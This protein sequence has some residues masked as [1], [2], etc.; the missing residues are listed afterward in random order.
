MIKNF[1]IENF[2]SI[3]T[4]DIEFGRVNVIIGENGSGKSN[5]LEAIAL[6]TAAAMNKLDREFLASRGI[7]DVEPS[8]MRA[9]FSKDNVDKPITLTANIQS[10]NN[11][12]R[13]KQTLHN[14]NKP[15]SKWTKEREI[16]YKRKSGDEVSIPEIPVLDNINN[17]FNEIKS[18]M[19]SIEKK[20]KE[21]RDFDF[22]KRIAEE[23]SRLNSRIESLEKKR[24]TI[25]SKI[26]SE[27][28]IPVDD[29][30]IYSPE[31]TALRNFYKEGQIEPL[32]VNGE[33]LLKLLKVT[34]ENDFDSFES[35]INYLNVFCWYKGLNISSDNS[36][37][38]LSIQLTDKFLNDV[39][40][41]QR[42]AN[43]G[44]L[45][46]LFYISLIISKETPKYIAI[47]NIDASLN[48]KLCT[49]LMRDIAE[50]AKN[51]DKQLFLTTHNPA[52]LDGL[53]LSDNEQKLFVASRTRE[54]HTKL[55]PL[56]ADIK[57]IQKDGTPMK[58]S[59]A[60][61]RGYLGG[62]PKGF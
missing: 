16:T 26:K 4:L 40:I 43:E 30:I 51:H 62:L 19:L 41:D 15:Y 57:P 45:F 37:D 10:Y 24:N 27:F 59:D 6:F 13:L 49:Q 22:E 33:G 32:G 39:K 8:L 1:K 25:D 47:D 9:C 36:E 35:I 5:I 17:A 28:K 60:L 34:K 50:L 48:P 44:F 29:F 20:T 23:L 21:E 42:S 12:F 14:D 18:M 52:I 3:N 53:D 7:R 54:G 46:V 61:M 2:K 11:D 31:N 56:S 58:L 38:D 55:K